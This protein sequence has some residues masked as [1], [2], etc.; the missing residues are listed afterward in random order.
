[1]RN[2]L[3][4]LTILLVILFLLVSFVY[5]ILG[6]FGAVDITDD[7]MF[8]YQK[9]DGV[10][11]SGSDVFSSSNTL[12]ANGNYELQV[13]FATGAV[14]TQG[15]YGQWLNTRKRVL[16][17]QEVKFA[18]NGEV[19]LC[20][21]YL[22]QYN[23]LSH[24]NGGRI[25]IG[26]VEKDA[27]VKLAFNSRISEWR[28]VIE[29]YP[30]DKIQITIEPA[31]N[32][33][34][35]LVSG[36][37]FQDDCDASKEQYQ[38]NCSRFTAQYG[39]YSDYLERC[40]KRIEKEWRDTGQR[41][42]PGN[43]DDD[44]HV[45]NK[46]WFR[47]KWEVCAFGICVG[48]TGDWGRFG[49]L[50]PCVYK[51]GPGG[52]H[53]Y[54]VGSG[55]LDVGV[56][57]INLGGG[58]YRG[59]RD[60]SEVV[61]GWLDTI[62]WD[63]Q[64]VSSIA[65]KHDGSNTI[66]YPE[67]PTDPSAFYTPHDDL[68]QYNCSVDSQ[69]NFVNSAEYRDKQ[70]YWHVSDNVTGLLWRTEANELPSNMGVR[71][72]NYRVVQLAPKSKKVIFDSNLATIGK[73]RKF[74]QLRFFNDDGDFGRN[75]G[76]YVI[77]VN[78]TKCIREHGAAK[79]DAGFQNRGQV[80]YVIMPSGVDPNYTQVTSGDITNI[81]FNKVE[82][83]YR[84]VRDPYAA[85]V[86]GVVWA[87]ILNKESDYRDSDGSY[88]FRISTEVGYQAFIDKIL[89]PLLNTIHN[90]VI[91]AGY[92]M[93]KNMTCYSDTS[94]EHCFDFFLYIKALLSLYIVSYGLL[95]L[96]GMTRISQQDLII[97]VIKIALV[98]GL[99]TGHTF[100]FFATYIFPIVVNFS[101]TIVSNVAG[102]ELYETAA[103]VPNPFIFL[104]AVVSR[105]LLSVTF[106]VQLFALWSI[107]LNGVIY[108][109]VLAV[110]ITLYL[111]TVARCFA[112]YIMSLLGLSLMIGMAPFFLTFMLFEATKAIFDK[113]VT[114][115]IRYMM[116]P[117]VLLVGMVI[118][119][120]LFTIY[121]D[122]VV[123]Y[124]V[125]W[126][127]ALTFKISFITALLPESFLNIPIFCINWFGPWGYGGTG[128]GADFALDISQ[129]AALMMITW[130]MYNYPEFSS[131]LTSNLVGGSAGSATKAGM[132]MNNAIGQGIKGAASKVAGAGKSGGGKKKRDSGSGGDASEDSMSR[133]GGS[134]GSSGESSGKS[135]DSLSDKG[136]AVLKKKTSGDA[137]PKPNSKG[138]AGKGKGAKSSSKGGGAQS[139]RSSS[140][141]TS[142]AAGTSSGGGSPKG[143]GGG[144][145]S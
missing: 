44:C 120:Q 123:S 10:L 9:K 86:D 36:S 105:L 90:I 124:S 141:S 77:G 60:C 3:L 19:S 65:F 116:E 109:L 55:G 127:C 62:Y 11:T 4:K 106:W 67:M 17:G 58:E 35:N 113:W 91:T 75:Q 140:S 82:S 57:S 15:K 29:I 6:V 108:F 42:C 112:I 111:I 144:T 1:M 39:Q 76:G 119:T 46:F 33:L 40:N 21:S 49:G 93:F 47:P 43:P 115:V 52:P 14:T 122:V 2:K 78:H 66:S 31:I 74:L 32:R 121:L 61:M 96:M 7:C 59:I 131:N 94:S 22:P 23:L 81:N 95:F 64:N 12:R 88:E 37:W 16:E 79:T 89:N 98:S 28:N 102:F 137:N 41:R 70:R 30:G 80:Q 97:R 8:R 130:C 87:R 143:N 68:K 117:V 13:D 72:G 83:S 84:T 24:S 85:H 92:N 18:I 139:N 5:M 103:G 138:N 104:D 51:G 100:D 114:Y 69:K 63:P 126:K 135:G 26:R 101:A 107:G 129:A 99:M 38:P 133:G 142:S 145:S 110:S 25:P 45:D 118:F 48:K 20:K 53:S 54:G 125:C 73:E 136:K 71:G 27:P 134:S 128:Q 34:K 50:K 132:A 56:G